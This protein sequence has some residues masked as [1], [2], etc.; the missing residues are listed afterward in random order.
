VDPR[1]RWIIGI[2]LALVIGLVVGLIIAVPIL[3]TIRILIQ[4]LWIQPMEQRNLTLAKPGPVAAEPTRLVE[5]AQ[6]IPL[7][8]GRRA[9]HQCARPRL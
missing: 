5:E 9:D 2:L 1:T 7:F 8:G 3:A 6:T 4:E